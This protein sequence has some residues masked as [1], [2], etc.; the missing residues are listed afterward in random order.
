MNFT[1]F[2]I[3]LHFLILHFGRQTDYTGDIKER[4]RSFPQ[5]RKLWLGGYA[6]C[7]KTIVITCRDDQVF[8]HSTYQLDLARFFVLAII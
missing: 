8:C 5:K 7:S 4:F 3:G 6:D 2:L 1:L